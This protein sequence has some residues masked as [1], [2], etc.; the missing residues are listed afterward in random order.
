[1]IERV[2][3]KK[4]LSFEEVELNFEE[5]ELNLSNGLMIFTG[6]SGSGKSV[7]LQ[8][9]LAIFGLYDAKAEVSEATISV[10]YGFDLNEYGI[11]IEDE[12]IFREV[13]KD[14]T[15]YF[16]NS[17]AV[18][19]KNIKEISK[20]FID[21]LSLKT[22]ED[23][24]S[25]SLLSLV[26]LMVDDNNFNSLKEKYIKSFIKY[27]N[28]K[29]ELNLLNSKEKESNELKEF[30][31]YEISK[32]ED[33][34]PKDGEFNELMKIKRELSKIEKIKSISNDVFSIF[35]Y[36]NE[37]VE[38]LEMLEIESD[39]FSDSMNELRSALDTIES[40]S[41]FL[42]SV[43]IEEVLN[44]IEDL[45]S[46]IKRF[47]NVKEALNYKEEKKAELNRLE[48][49]SF[50]KE[51]I[52]KNIKKLEEE[53]ILKSEKLTKFREKGVI[54]F[55]KRLNEFLVKLYMPNSN[56]YLKDVDL[57]SYGKDK[58]VLEIEDTNIDSLSTGEFNRLRLALLA[59]KIEYTDRPK[60][61]FLDEIDANL[62]GEESMSVANVLKL[63]SKKYQIFAISHQPQ[64]TSQADKHF[65]VSK[66][67]NISSV[68]ELDKNER[69]EEIARIISGKEFKK[70]AIEYAK[71]L[72]N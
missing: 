66:K 10:D 35:N 9:I 61:L 23:F 26:D 69:I 45:N 6:P 32:I 13:K 40:R 28:L 7:L 2:Y 64:L 62:S 24:E 8:G 49:L 57:N 41:E 71:K 36:E 54:E 42:E 63:L 19:K 59:S 18:S 51:E 60:S 44:R 14:K 34:D 47:G 27:Q 33:I 68:K 11:D 31:K 58:V 17:Q 72:I 55:Q 29:K 12:V 50:E 25:H 48:N 15:R 21:Y 22:T 4:H 38:L 20:K 1:L 16:I 56:I 70:E 46:I 3:L 30:L 39:F 5:V 65:L 43:N 53:L 67:E 37:V 52:E